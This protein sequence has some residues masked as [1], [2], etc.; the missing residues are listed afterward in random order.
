M[1]VKGIQP[2]VSEYHILWEAV[3]SY[4]ARLE[5]LSAMST[6]EDQRLKYDEKLHDIEGIKKSL[7]I[8]A[9]QDYKLKL[10]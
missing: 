8:A 9:M 1:S 5:K 4:E 3:T 2:I 10:T 7:Q 6:D